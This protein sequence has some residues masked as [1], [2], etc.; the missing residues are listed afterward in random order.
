MTSQQATMF[1]RF[2]A[3][4]AVLAESALACGC[5]AY[6]DIFTYNRWKAQGLQVQKGQKAVKLPL[7]R[8][9]EHKE[10]GE[11]THRRQLTSSAVFCR[12]QVSPTGETKE[13]AEEP[14]PATTLALQPIATPAPEPTST[15]D[16]LMSNWKEV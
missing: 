13:K 14:A 15:L 5:K 6:E 7:V 11:I 10:T 8:S 16:S 1:D 12:H 9:I 2:S 4:N 3:G